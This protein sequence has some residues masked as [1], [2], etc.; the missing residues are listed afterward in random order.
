M[1]STATA[2]VHQLLSGTLPCQA[3][4]E[5]ADPAAGPHPTWSRNCCRVAL[6][7]MSMPL[8]HCSPWYVTRSVTV[9]PT[10]MSV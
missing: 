4:A 8:N 3:H 10:S 9:S 6:E 5:S 7:A 1:L 2:A